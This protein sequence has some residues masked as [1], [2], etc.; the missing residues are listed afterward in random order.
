MRTR[1]RGEGMRSG[2]YLNGA[3]EIQFVI[4]RSMQIVRGAGIYREDPDILL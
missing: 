3:R 2:M 1:R 4:G